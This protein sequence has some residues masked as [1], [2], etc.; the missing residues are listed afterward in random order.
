MQAATNYSQYLGQIGDFMLAK[1]ILTKDLYFAEI[2]L[3]V[4]LL[5]K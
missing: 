1:K 4:N 2:Y 3:S 5:A